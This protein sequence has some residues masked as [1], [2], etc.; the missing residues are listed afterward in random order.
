MNTNVCLYHWS[1]LTTVWME[2]CGVKV[3][4]DIQLLSII[5]YIRQLGFFLEINGLILPG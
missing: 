4:V 2:D 3:S 1:N 5:H